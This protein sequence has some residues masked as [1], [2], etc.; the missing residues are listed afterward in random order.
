MAYPVHPVPKEQVVERRDVAVGHPVTPAQGRR[1]WVPARGL[2]RRAPGTWCTPRRPGWC[3]VALVTPR[4]MNRVRRRKTQHAA[5]A[6]SSSKQQQQQ[7]AAVAAARVAAASSSKEQQQA[8]ATKQHG[9]RREQQASKRR[10]RRQEQPKKRRTACRAGRS[11]ASGLRIALRRV[12]SQPRAERRGSSVKAPRQ[13]ARVLGCLALWSRVLVISS[14]F[15]SFAFSLCLLVCSAALRAVRCAC[16]GRP[17]TSWRPVLCSSTLNAIH[18][19][20]V[21]LSL[22]YEN[23]RV[24]RGLRQEQRGP[25]LRTV[26]VAKDLHGR[27]HVQD[28]GLHAQAV[29]HSC[30]QL[31][32]PAPP[33]VGTRPKGGFLRVGV[34]T[35]PT[36]CTFSNGAEK[37]RQPRSL[38]FWNIPGNLAR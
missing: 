22:R 38:L 1:R 17:D 31:P 20:R 12:K 7:A 4:P 19:S 3:D 24:A 2:C 30:A 29:L 28:G 37:G 23:L 10:R 36:S 5:A 11:T 26:D 21:T 8:A 9:R 14:L 18:Q 34:G 13:H 35:S 15:S 33:G 6:A 32:A 27:G 16:A 25:E